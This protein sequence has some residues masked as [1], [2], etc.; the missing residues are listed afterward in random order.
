MKIHTLF[1]L[2]VVL[3]VMILSGCGGK[4]QRLSG[5]VTFSDDGTPVPHGAIFFTDGQFM[6]Q[7][8]IKSDG[9]YVVGTKEK[10]DGIPPG[11]YKV[12]F[13][14]VELEESVTTPDGFSDRKYTPLISSKYGDPE[15]SGLIFTADGSTKTF[16]VQ[17]DRAK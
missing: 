5:K 9:T 10:T 11:T 12:Y 4:N 7:G 17:L 2:S 8:V 15:T 14:G 1:V 13:A 3:C 6:S 16:D